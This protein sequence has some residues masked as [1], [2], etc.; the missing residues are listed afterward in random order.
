MSLESA[1]KFLDDAM[2]NPLVKSQL[3]KMK[4]KDALA[5]T[6][7][8]LGKQMGYDFSEADVKKALEQA[9]GKLSD[10]DLGDVAGGLF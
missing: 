1:K 5:K 3:A 6:A 10:A 8:S 7:V 4:D 9:D 2:K